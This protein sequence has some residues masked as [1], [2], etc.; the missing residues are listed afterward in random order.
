M[1]AKLVEDGF[2]LFSKD[3]YSEA[4]PLLERMAKIECPPAD[5]SLFLG[6]SRSLAS[7]D[8]KYIDEA[9]NEVKGNLPEDHIC[10]VYGFALWDMGLHDDGA[11]YLRKSVELNPSKGNLDV[12][13][14]RF[15]TVPALG[16]EALV[17]CNML[18]A[19]QPNDNMALLGRGCILEGKGLFAEALKDFQEASR[20]DPNEPGAH[21]ELGN[22]LVL[23]DD[24]EAALE[25]F[26][27]HKLE[28][29]C[30]FVT[31]ANC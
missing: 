28:L 20:I 24:T 18:L 30:V 13:V 17:Y 15:D 1:N 6:A 10:S 4:I 2:D 29:L 23:M 21:Y 26:M 14:C 8:R 3:K 31:S 22:L 19:I 27:Q 12:C 25:E 5:A 16:E 11:V 9:V 7:G